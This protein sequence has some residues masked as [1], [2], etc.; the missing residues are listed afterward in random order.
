MEPFVCKT[1]PL[2]PPAPPPNPPSTQAASTILTGL[3]SEFCHRGRFLC[4]AGP[5]VI[6]EGGGRGRG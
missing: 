1:A 5:D 4:L 3:G 2:P 6:A